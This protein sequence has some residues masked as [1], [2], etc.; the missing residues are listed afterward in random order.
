[1]GDYIRARWVFLRNTFHALRWDV[2]QNVEAYSQH[3]KSLSLF[4]E[5]RKAISPYSHTHDPGSSKKKEI[6]FLIE[7]RPCKVLTKTHPLL[8]GHEAQPAAR[9]MRAFS[10]F[11]YPRCFKAGIVP[12]LKMSRNCTSCLRRANGFAQ[13]FSINPVRFKTL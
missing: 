12:A 2:F 4:P 7:L 10:F 3:E 9:G 1:M 13:Y 8:P 5:D 11:R 6:K